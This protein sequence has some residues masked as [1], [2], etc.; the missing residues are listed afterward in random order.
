M[1]YIKSQT[2]TISELSE[3]T[4][5]LYAESG[6][7]IAGG[8]VAQSGPSVSDVFVADSRPVFDGGGWG[9][10]VRVINR[11]TEADLSLTIYL[12]CVE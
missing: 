5:T 3:Q 8:G 6:E 1:P 10:L 11:S 9:W 7:T 4:N 12:V 2:Y